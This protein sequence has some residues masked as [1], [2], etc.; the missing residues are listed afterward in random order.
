MSFSR[1]AFVGSALALAACE[2]QGPATAAAQP[3]RSGPL[4]RLR[5]LVPFP[6]G[7]QLVSDHLAIPSVVDLASTQFDQIT[8][9]YDLKMEY[10]VQPDG[11]L[12][13]DGPDAL[14]AFADAN[15]QSLHGHTLVWYADEPE[16]FQRL[17]GRQAAFE[18]AYDNHIT[19]VAGRYAGRMRSWDVV[20]E[21]VTDEGRSLRESLWTRNLGQDGHFERAFHLTHEA[22][23]GAL[24]FTNE[25]HL[26]SKPH[27]RRTFLNLIER[28]LS[29]GVPIHGIGHQSHLLC[30]LPRGAVAEAMREIASLGLPIHMSEVDVSLQSERPFGSRRDREAAQIRLYQET[31]EAYMDLPRIQQFAYTIWGVRDAES[32]VRQDWYGGDHTDAPLLW[33]DNGLPK[34]TYWAVADAMRARRMR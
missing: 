28:M 5:D 8:T 30:D 18:R 6:V 26:E 10:L 1:R 3:A 13:F 33:D 32:W 23:P 14:A 24:L 16:F 29:R 9:G 12:R 4:P 25:Y 20:N 22:D 2:G 21:P 19:T 15:G 27:K 11:R 7:T 34:P 17:D 31:I